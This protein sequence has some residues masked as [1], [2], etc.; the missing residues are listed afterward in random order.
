MLRL[1]LVVE[2]TTDPLAHLAQQRPSVGT[3][4][5]ALQHRTHQPDT[6]EIA[7]D[8]IGDVRMLNLHRDEQAVD[9]AS[10]MDLTH[11]SDRERLLVNGGENVLNA[12]VQLLLAH[13]SHTLQRKRLHVLR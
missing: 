9:R 10:A 3:G 11:A 4:R 6:A 1:D 2:L 8:R 13:A 12:G 7:S 5:Q